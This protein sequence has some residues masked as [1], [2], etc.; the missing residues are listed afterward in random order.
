MGGRGKGE[1]PP[2]AITLLHAEH[3]R[4]GAVTCR[5]RSLNL[6]YACLDPVNQSHLSWVVFK[7][8]HQSIPKCWEVFNPRQNPGGSGDHEGS[9]DRT[10]LLCAGPMPSARTLS[11]PDERWKNPSLRSLQWRLHNV[12]DC[13]PGPSIPTPQ[14]SDVPP[15]TM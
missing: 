9:T 11:R 4:S 5:G 10:G 12:R 6:L 14:R 1:R 2:S 15:A 7:G 13:L 8:W 3:R